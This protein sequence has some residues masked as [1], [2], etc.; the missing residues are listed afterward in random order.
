MGLI[1]VADRSGNP[2]AVSVETNANTGAALDLP[3]RLVL[4][5]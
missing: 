2:E 3:F 1:S 5:C 4:A